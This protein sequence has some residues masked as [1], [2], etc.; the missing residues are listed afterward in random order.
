MDPMKKGLADR[1][2]ET[3]REQLESVAATQREAIERVSGWC[4]DCLG[5]ER[6]IYLFGTGHSHLLAEELFYRAGGLTRVVPMLHGPLMLHESAAESTRFERD[7]GLVEGLLETYPIDAGDVLVVASNSG[8]NPVPVELALQAAAR[9]AR[10]CAIVNRRHG[11][12]WPSRHPSG[13]RLADV[14]EIGIDNC[15][16]PGDA[17]VPVPALN[18][19]V[20]ASSTV[21]GAAILQMI[22][23]GAV[24]KAMEQGV[25]PEV[26]MS[27]NADDA[28]AHNAGLLKSYRG[29]VPHL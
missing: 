9:G 7:I 21:V 15:G 28:E 24:E 19:S 6:W 10:V 18:A 8:R 12:R 14:A 23:C 27:S 29:R 3:I 16:V 2:L 26:F 4:A 20:G 11:E 17:C 1:Y 13:K 25:K 5:T 22:A